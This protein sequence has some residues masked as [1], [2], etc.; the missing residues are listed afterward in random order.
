[1][2]NVYPPTA[3]VVTPSLSNVSDTSQTGSLQ[4]RSCTI[5]KRKRQ[6]RPYGQNMKIGNA[7]IA[8]DFLRKPIRWAIVL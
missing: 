8:E 5:E 4:S 1:M 2:A 3:G 6:L 7:F